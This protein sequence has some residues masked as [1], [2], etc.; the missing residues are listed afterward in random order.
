MIG[1]GSADDALTRFEEAA[2]KHANATEIGDYMTANRC[3]AV[4]SKAVLFLK[5]NNEVQLCSGNKYPV[6]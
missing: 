1:L 4:I 5:F 6:R 3:Y 2:Y